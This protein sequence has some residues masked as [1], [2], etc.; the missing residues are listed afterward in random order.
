[1]TDSPVLETLETGWSVATITERCRVLH[2]TLHAR[3]VPT[4]EL[5]AMA[6]G[7]A[8][9]QT[10]DPLGAAVVWYALLRAR[11]ELEQHRAAETTARAQADV[12][13]ALSA[14]PVTVRL[15]A[16]DAPSA[17]YPKSYHALRFLDT[18]DH[19]L[20]RVVAIAQEADE[21]G[22][23]AFAPLVESLAV[24]LWAWILTSVGSE[25]PFD[26]QAAP[27]PP[28]WTRALTPDDLL[29]LLEAHLEVNRARVARIAQLFPGDATHESRLSL[30]GFLGTTA[31]EL[32]HR[33]FDLLRRWSVGEAFAQ[34]VVAA[35][36][37]REAR[38]AAEEAA[39]RKAS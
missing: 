29:A 38:A 20:R 14:E 13:A 16:P 17:V 3:K 25:L 32:G 27:E 34:A 39:Q 33:P 10:A 36:S 19:A 11:F 22:V 24:R 18:L 35:Q 28:E 12:A 37:A 2:G 23:E 21:V 7:G 8:Q 4:P 9:N 30:A 5:E 15:Q 1:V 31:Q 6:P 26:E